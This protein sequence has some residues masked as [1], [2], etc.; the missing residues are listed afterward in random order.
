MCLGIPIGVG[1]FL[2]KCVFD[3]IWTLVWSQKSQKFGPCLNGLDLWRRRGVEGQC[4]KNRLSEH[5]KLSFD[6]FPLAVVRKDPFR[7]VL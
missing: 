4:T 2:G 1:S 7:R 6:M 3:P 5:P